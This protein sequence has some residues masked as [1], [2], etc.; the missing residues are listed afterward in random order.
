MSGEKLDTATPIMNYQKM[1]SEKANQELVALQTANAKIEGM[2]AREKARI[3][4]VVGGAAELGTYLDSNNIEGGERYLNSRRQE[5]GKRIAAGEDVDTRETDEAL[6]ILRSRDPE[7]IKQLQGHIGQMKKLGQLRG[8]LATDK[9]SDGYTLGPGQKRFD[10]NNNEVASGPDKVGNMVPVTD[11]ITGETTY[12]PVRKL[13]ATDQREIYEAA[14][15]IQSGEGA[16]NALLRAKQIMTGGATGEEAKPYSGVGASARAAVARVPVVGDIVAEPERGAAT[17]EYSTLVTE[18]ALGS[19]KAIFGGMPTEG[20]R[21][22]LLQMQAIADYTPDEQ[23]RIIDNALAAID[24]RNSFNKTKIESIQKGDYSALG[25]TDA[26]ETVAA[27][28][29]T[30]RQSSSQDDPL[31]LR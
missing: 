3:E 20:E 6:E 13:S 24:R 18:Q 26:N 21:K 19:L 14:D 23:G 28:T 1:K 16:R 15:V 29:T 5:L 25:R 7:K 31:G 17:T 12:E 30:P 11:P 8:I 4:S 10:A 27:P 9:A 2:S 22:I